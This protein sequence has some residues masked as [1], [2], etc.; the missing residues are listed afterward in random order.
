LNISQEVLDWLLAGPAWVRY[1]VELQLLNLKPDIETVLQDSSIRKILGRLKEGRSGFPALGTNHTSYTDTGNIYWDLFF[2]AD[3]GL[4][5]KEA[6]LEKE[7]G[8]VFNFQ[9]R[10]GA[11]VPDKRT[12]PNY[13]CMSAILLASIARI[14]YKDDAR[15]RSYVKLLLNSRQPDGGWHC[16]K[17]YAQRSCPMDNQNVLMLLGQYEEYRE[18]RSLRSAIDLLLEHW[19]RRSEGWRPDGFGTGQRF[20]RLYYPA[21]KYSILRVLDV[22]SLFPYAIRSRSFASM[23]ESVQMK[24][25]SG[26][27][28][29][30]AVDEAYADFDFGQS[31]E[32]SRWL[33]FLVHR[34]EKRVKDCS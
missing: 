23:L 13:Y 8:Q 27:Y 15:V 28:F 32:P 7:I 18:D 2:L 17:E 21:V 22:L 24:S 34:I 5:G 16:F 19:E 11:F 25:I 31:E 9:L 26:R 20:T 12:Q 33:T 30:E 1:A 6:G 10:N 29:A 14:G 3:I 4:T